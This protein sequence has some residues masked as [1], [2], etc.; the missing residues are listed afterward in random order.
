MKGCYDPITKTIFVIIASDDF[1]VLY[2]INPYE[3]L[4]KTVEFCHVLTI[5]EA[6]NIFVI[7]SE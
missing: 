7:N 2:K 6:N 4:E 3:Q 1:A 5:C